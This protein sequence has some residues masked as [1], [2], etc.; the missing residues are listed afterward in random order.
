MDKENAVHRYN[1]ILLSHEKN[2]IMPFEA[3]RWTHFPDGASGKESACQCR[4]N[5][6]CWFDP[7]VG[8][9]PWRRKL[10]PTPVF[11]P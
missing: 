11:L 6:R 7:W 8:K 4:R 1:E 9:I 2:E 5:K 10:H 3:N